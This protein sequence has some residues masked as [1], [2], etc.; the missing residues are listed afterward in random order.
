MLGQGSGKAEGAGGGGKGA[1]RGGETIEGGVSEGEEEEEEEKDPKQVGG[2]DGKAVGVLQRCA[3]GR[4]THVVA[5]GVAQNRTDEVACSNEDEGSVGSKHC[6]VGELEHCR[7]EDPRQRP[8]SEP[9]QLDDMVEVSHSKEE[10]AGEDGSRRAGTGHQHG[11]HA[12]PEH[13]LLC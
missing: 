5:E 4:E 12:G 13:Q 6:C 8:L 1:D 11:Q 10:R 9:Q 2:E 3:D 7:E